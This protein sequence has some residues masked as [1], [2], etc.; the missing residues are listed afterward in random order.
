MPDTDFTELEREDARKAAAADRIV[1]DMPCSYAGEVTRLLY[2]HF[3]DNL[4]RP[5]GYVEDTDES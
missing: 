3:W 5:T 2:R 4:D 1:A